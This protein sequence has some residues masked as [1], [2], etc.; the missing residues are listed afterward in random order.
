MWRTI[1][2]MSINQRKLAAKLFY[3]I[4]RMLFNKG[5]IEQQFKRFKITVKQILFKFKPTGDIL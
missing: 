1:L 3:A 5:P 2:K 4:M